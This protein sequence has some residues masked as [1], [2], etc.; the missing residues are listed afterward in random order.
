MIFIKTRKP[1]ILIFKSFKHGWDPKE[2]TNKE[3][4]NQERKVK[5][6]PQPQCTMDEY[7]LASL[8]IP[9]FQRVLGRQ[10][11]PSLWRHVHLYN[12]SRPLQRNVLDAHN[13]ILQ[14]N[15]FCHVSRYW[16]IDFNSLQG[17]IGTP[18]DYDQNEMGGC[19]LWEQIDSGDQFT[20]S[21]KFLTAVPILL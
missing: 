21:K 16:I 20:P 4:A 2:H 13:P 18:F 7:I 3:Y 14:Y 8:L 19:T 5:I 17:I 11:R 6:R 10:S 9:R 12:L 1:N 15:N